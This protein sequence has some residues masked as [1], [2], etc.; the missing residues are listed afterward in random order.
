[1]RPTRPMSVGRGGDRTVISLIELKGFG[2]RWMRK[3]RGKNESKVTPTQV[4]G[5]MTSWF[6]IEMG[7]LL[8]GGAQGGLLVS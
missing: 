7:N 3:G 8:L 2:V 6:I 4:A 1:M 5:K